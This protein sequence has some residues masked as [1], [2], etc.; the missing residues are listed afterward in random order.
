MRQFVSENNPDSKGLLEIT[1]KNYR[2]LKQVLRLA[3]GDMLAVRLPSGILSN[4]T[5]A[6]IDEAKK[7]VIL[8]ICGETIPESGENQSSYSLKTEFW[9]FQFVAKGPKMDLI[10]RQAAECGVSKI[11]PVTGDFTQAGGSEKKFRS[12]RYERIIREARQQS[13]SPVATVIAETVTLDQAC[14]MWKDEIDQQGSGAFGCVLY[15]RNENTSSILS[16]LNNKTELK[17]CALV[18]GAEG[19][20]SPDEI[21]KMA[22]SGFTPVHL[23]TNILRCETAALYG[24]ACLQN[25]VAEKNSC[26]TK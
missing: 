9:L 12:D 14:I 6:R 3:V 26:Q 11:I 2:Y 13:G 21:K 22:E 8:Q 16:A 15:E 25:A 24:T 17:T 5:V 4:T 1:G 23:E 10:V 20:I 7:K 18:C 19:G